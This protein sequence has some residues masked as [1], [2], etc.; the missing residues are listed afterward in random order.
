M[1]NLESIIKSH[2]SKVSTTQPTLRKP[3]NCP[4]TKPCPLNGKCLTENI[5][6]SAT[7]TAN[8]NNNSNND[9]SNNNNNS[10]N[11]NSN[12]NNSSSSATQ[13]S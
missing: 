13:R 7:V 6:Y 11:N 2:N 8:N 1:A 9:N 10:I 12:N 5:I 4:K 3:C